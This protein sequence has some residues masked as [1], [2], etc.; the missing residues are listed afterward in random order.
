MTVKYFLRVQAFISADIDLSV[1]AALA[2]ALSFP[3][4]PVV[5]ISAMRIYL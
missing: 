1:N 2:R 3:V 5:G 4:S